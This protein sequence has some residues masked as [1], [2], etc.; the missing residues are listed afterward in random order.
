MI[1]L[2]LTSV[3]LSCLLVA[4]MAQLD[5]WMDHALAEAHQV[6][7]SLA[8]LRGLKADVGEYAEEGRLKIESRHT[9]NIL[10]IAWVRAHPDAMCER[11]ANIS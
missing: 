9:H 6:F 11:S 8:S 10:R 3:L 2:H 7:D 5:P 4:T 1:L